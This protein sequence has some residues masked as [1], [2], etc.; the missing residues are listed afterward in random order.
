MKF[1]A[2]KPPLRQAANRYGQFYEKQLIQL[3]F[4]ILNQISIPLDTKLFIH[5]K[6]KPYKSNKMK[7]IILTFFFVLFF[8]SNNVYGQDNQIIYLERV[9]DFLN[10]TI[11]ID[12]TKYNLSEHTNFGLFETDT[13]SIFT[14]KLFSDVD[15]DF[16]RKQF[17]ATEKFKW[18]ENKILGAKIIPEKNLRKIFKHRKNGWNKFRKKYG[19]CL[20]SFSLPIFNK[21]FTYC[22]FYQW[23]QCDYLAGYGS[24]GLYKFENSKW[25]FI[26]HYMTGIS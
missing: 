23:T 3:K 4:K 2:E 17:S 18:Q 15:K 11:A 10:S 7:N 24:L 5:N 22:I 26:K 21:D 19:N 16:F 25:I 8:V 12:T 6:P 14:D 13:T 20:T 9:Y 1:C